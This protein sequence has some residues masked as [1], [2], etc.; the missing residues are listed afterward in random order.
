M[1]KPSNAHEEYL[2]REA[3]HISVLL[4]TGC[5]VPLRFFM[6]LVHNYGL[7]LSWVQSQVT[8][9]PLG[10]LS[11]PK[12]CGISISAD[13]GRPDYSDGSVFLRLTTVHLPGC[14]VNTK[15][16][17]GGVHDGRAYEDEPVFGASPLSL[18]VR[19]SL[20]RGE[21]IPEFPSPNEKEQP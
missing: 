9:C 11:V 21:Y 4:P 17:F 19:E 10:M 3:D 2:R 20:E 7:Q 8:P 16:E 5:L 13:K 1:T 15:W 12:V 6:A 14:G 18:R